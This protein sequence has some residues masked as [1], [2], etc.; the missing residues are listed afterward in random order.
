ML[1]GKIAI[2]TGAGS[3]LGQACAIALAQEGATAVVTELP[4]RRDRAM[5]TVALIEREGGVALSIV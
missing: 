2:V 1:A 4:D 5:E 3:G